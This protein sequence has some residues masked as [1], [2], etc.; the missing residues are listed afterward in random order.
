MDDLRILIA[1]L[2]S[3]APASRWWSIQELAAKLGAPA[4]AADT[5]A[6]LL[7]LLQSRKLEAEV[8]EVLCIFW[9]ATSA[10]GYASSAKLPAHTPKPSL[11]SNPFLEALGFA[12]Q[13]LNADLEAAPK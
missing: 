11:L 10:Y 7:K 4:T 9:I 2:G 1:R 6:A 13:A 12:A 8:V 5:E 3:P